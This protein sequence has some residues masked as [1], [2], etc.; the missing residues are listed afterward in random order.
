MSRYAILSFLAALAA[1]TQPAA[2]TGDR[3]GAPPRVAEAEAEA[4]AGADAGA[5]PGA[6]ELIEDESTLTFTAT[7][8]GA[9]FT[10]RFREFDAIIDLDPESPSDGTVVG[11]V[12]MDSVATGDS[13]RDGYLVG[14]E[15]FHA[16]RWPRARFE[17]ES[18][19]RVEDGGYVAEG[20]LRL[21]DVTRPVTMRF[22]FTPPKDG[23]PGSFEGGFEI[24]R[25]NFGVG[26]GEWE[27]TEWVGNEVE[28]DVDLALA[29]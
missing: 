2:E 5:P 19:S 1:C 4:G 28:I 27:S 24:E 25:L 9:K 14:E 8:Q 17:S 13:E 6:Y 15:W 3:E 11:I 12:E 16:S 10:G 7:Q 21:R 22:E 26:Q 20:S 29:E 23:E 18:I